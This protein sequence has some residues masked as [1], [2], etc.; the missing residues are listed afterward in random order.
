MWNFAIKVVFSGQHLANQLKIQSLDEECFCTNLHLK[1]KHYTFSRCTRGI[2]LFKCK[3]ILCQLILKDVNSV[4]LTSSSLPSPCELNIKKILAA[5]YISVSVYMFIGHSFVARVTLLSSD[6]FSLVLQLSL[7]SH[8]HESLSNC[9]LRPSQRVLIQVNV[10][11]CLRG[12]AF[13]Q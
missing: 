13:G 1:V 3:F 2:I 12:L 5:V 7:L 11:F 6:S 4:L 10:G 8:G 9:L